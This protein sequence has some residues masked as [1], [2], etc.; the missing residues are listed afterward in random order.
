MLLFA[1]LS[2]VFSFLSLLLSC[3]VGGTCSDA[4]LH[5]SWLSSVL[6]KGKGLCEYTFGVT[7]G[8][9]MAIFSFNLRTRV[10]FVFLFDFI[11]NHRLLSLGFWYI[12]D[13]AALWDFSFLLGLPRIKKSGFNSEKLK[14]THD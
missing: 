4:S 9:F 13:L 7:V 3:V 12:L 5:R 10:V 2:L 1:L 14:Q 6:L 8:L 11:T